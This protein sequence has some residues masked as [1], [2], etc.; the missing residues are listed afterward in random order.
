KNQAVYRFYS[1]PF[2]QDKAAREKLDQYM[3]RKSS[4]EASKLKEEMKALQERLKKME[5]RLNDLDR[6]K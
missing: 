2:E 3:S 1:A 4:D 6:R 5:E